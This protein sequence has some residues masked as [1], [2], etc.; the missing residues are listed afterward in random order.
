MNSIGETLRRAREER[1]LS[2]DEVAARTRIQR[3]YLEAIEAD[4]R[5]AMPGGFFYKS[6]VRQYAAALSPEVA[7]DIDELLAAEEPSPPAPEQD[8]GTFKALASEPRIPPVTVRDSRPIL[9]YIVLLVMAIVGSSGLYMWWHRSTQRAQASDE[10]SAVVASKPGKAPV[11]EPKT[12]AAPPATAPAGTAVSTPSSAP[13]A[14]GD[15]IVLDIAAS[16]DTWFSLTA[17]GKQVFTGILSPGQT[18]TFGAKDSARLSVGNAGGL[19]VKL[20]GKP[21][22]P[23]GAHAQVRNVVFT[24]GGF[25]IAKPAPKTKPEETPQPGT[26]PP[27]V[28]P[29]DRS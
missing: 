11:E 2:L 22:G 25:T 20:N 7:G 1:S 3:K 16:E 29:A 9:T 12:A 13:P 26:E 28:P 23:L 17:D 19:E 15:N 4:D 8:P 24:P 18:K 6:F 14:P 21:V 5:A 10:T 27:P